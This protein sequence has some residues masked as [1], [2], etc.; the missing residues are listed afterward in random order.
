M[1]QVMNPGPARRFTN[2]RPQTTSQTPPRNGVPVESA[3]GA[4]VWSLFAAAVPT[5]DRTKAPKQ[6]KRVGCFMTPH[7]TRA[8][9]RP[10]PPPCCKNKNARSRATSPCHGL[11]D[12]AAR[13][14]RACG[15]WGGVATKG[16]LRMAASP[17]KR[18][19][20]ADARAPSSRG[21]TWLLSKVG[22]LSCCR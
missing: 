14:A 19:R 4:R 5:Q 2:R 22:F 3:F 16:R 9:R 18:K 11:M 20:A 10:P 21:R 12:V 17:A 6:K 7:Y 1:K 15:T 13:R 8:S